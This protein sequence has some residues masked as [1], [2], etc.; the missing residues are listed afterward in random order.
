MSE[1]NF[2]PAQS[3]HTS[4]SSST[5]SDRTFGAGESSAGQS[6]ADEF[7]SPEHGSPEH[8][9]PEH[10][11]PVHGSP[12]HGSPVHG[13]P[14]PV[15]EPDHTEPHGPSAVA[16]NLGGLRLDQPDGAIPEIGDADAMVV[17]PTSPSPISSPA[18]PAQVRF[19]SQTGP[20]GQ[21]FDPPVQ[22]RPSYGAAYPTPSN[23]VE[24]EQWAPAPGSTPGSATSAYGSHPSPGADA[25]YGPQGYNPQSRGSQGYQPSVR[26]GAAPSSYNP[27][28]YDAPGNSGGYH[29]A[30]RSAAGY[31][32]AAYNTARHPATGYNTQTAYV[33]PQD[34]DPR[35]TSG[36]RAVGAGSFPSS[37]SYSGQTSGPQ[38]IS[39][40][41]PQQPPVAGKKRLSAALVGAALIIAFG[42]GIGGGYL[43]AGM[44][45]NNS[46]APADTSLTQLSSAET[47][48]S[49]APAGSVE[50]VAATVLP[51]VVSVIATSQTS[52]GEGSGV[53][54]T[55]DGYILT[56]NHV[57]AGATDLTVRFNG[58][59]TGT[60]TVVG[61]DPTSDLAVI[62]VADVTGLT[63]ASLGTSGNLT[64]GEPVVAIGSPLGLSATVT[65]G[66]VSALN[67]PVRTAAESGGP[68][69]QQQLPGQRGQSTAA[70]SDTV[71]NAIQTDAAINPGNSGGPLVDMSGKIIGINSAIAS[72]STDSQSQSGFI[73]VGFAIPIDSATRVANEI[74]KTGSATHAVLGASVSDAAASKLVSTGAQI[75]KLTAAGPAETAGLQVGD[76]ITK[77]NGIPTESSDALVAT[78][79]SAA[80]GAKIDVTLLRG[81]ATETITVTLGTSS[82][83]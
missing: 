10:G 78:I 18:Y 31:Y 64:V 44:S 36:Q 50:Q 75:S 73:G 20:I 17:Y 55:K 26:D 11:S 8:G 45:G 54:L 58:G 1:N 56:N 23:P 16:G 72:L 19:D 41:T 82:A 83:S 71:L 34:G 13:S 62:K 42:A 66:I 9:S 38:H 80:P 33:R 29:P 39:A 69:Q 48:S 30:D 5:P 47:A 53:I 6:S 4:S 21:Q 52:G 81:T 57:V 40:G 24:S 46:A 59:T 76:V 22:G 12:V 70:S 74:I 35:I 3:D 2:P 63:P 49:T 7:R 67:R 43:G 27:S 68:Q 28:P 61:T 25:G 15:F 77:V 14:T 32:P 51:S 37:G 60:A 79:R 65:T